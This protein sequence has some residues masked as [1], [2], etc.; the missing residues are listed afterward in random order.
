MWRV[1]PQVRRRISE[2]DAQVNAETTGRLREI[3]VAGAAEAAL[4]VRRAA[5]VAARLDMAG[6]G[7]VAFKGVALI[8][9][10]YGDTGARM[11]ADFDLLVQERDLTAVEASAVAEGFHRMATF[12]HASLG[13]WKR[14]VHADPE[15]RDPSFTYF[16]DTGVAVDAHVGVGF[17]PAP[18]MEVATVIARAERHV[19]AGRS[20]VIASPLDAQVL[21]AHHLISSEFKPYTAV[22]DFCDL[23]AWWGTWPERWDLDHLVRLTRASGLGAGLLGGWCALAA[24]D[25]EAT[26]ATVGVPALERELRPSDRRDARHLVRLFQHQLERGQ[27]HPDLELLLAQPARVLYALRNRLSGSKRNGP[28]DGT[29]DDRG[30]LRQPVPPASPDEDPRMPVRVW[31]LLGEAL[32]FGRLT[33]HVRAQ[34]IQRRYR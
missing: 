3:A 34:R 22:K 24:R 2:L 17:R 9:G 16:D 18:A 13:E 14:A 21:T 26:V 5:A 11:V 4:V 31:Q 15:M 8:A 19:L 20:M 29:N 27:L 7:Y 28:E 10:L 12:E 25:P 32:R 23:Q 30:A 6:V 33:A 1:A